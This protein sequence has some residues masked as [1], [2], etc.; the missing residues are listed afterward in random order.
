MKRFAS[1]IAGVLLAST[2]CA[3]QE[4][5]DKPKTIKID[6]GFYCIDDFSRQFF[7]AF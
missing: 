1:L 5:N 4:K 6:E 3:A 2:V 7:F